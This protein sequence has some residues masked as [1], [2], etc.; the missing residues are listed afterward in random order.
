M[1]FRSLTTFATGLFLLA[2]VAA[3]ACSC[4][5]PGDAATAARLSSVVFAGRVLGWRT[6]SG[7]FGAER[8]VIFA[9]EQVWKGK[10][11]RRLEVRTAAS[12][13]ACGFPFERNHTYF[14]YAV[15]DERGQLGTALCSR[16]ALLSR[17]VADAVALGKSV[18]LEAD[19]GWPPVPVQVR[20]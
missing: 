17:A 9:V 13:S 1:T 12:T 8:A 11:V 19:P 16:T 6:V 4:A 14:V 18:A 7:R 5:G 3:H 2:P 10:P 15:A 20:P